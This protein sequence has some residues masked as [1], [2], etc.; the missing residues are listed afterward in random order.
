MDKGAQRRLIML[1]SKLDDWLV[2]HMGC[3]PSTKGGNNV[4]GSNWLMISN[5]ICSV[6]ARG[7]RSSSISQRPMI[8]WNHP[9]IGCC[10]FNEVPP[11]RGASTMQSLNRGGRRE[12]SFYLMGPR[13]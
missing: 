8:I 6:L 2:H 10:R 9:W 5:V 13:M 4:Y 11:W 1:P 12:M 7:I 3:H